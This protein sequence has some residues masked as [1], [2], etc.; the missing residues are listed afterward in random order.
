[1]GKF[2]LAGGNYGRNR[3]LSMGGIAHH[4][5]SQELATAKACMRVL[6]LGYIGLAMT[7][8]ASALCEDIFG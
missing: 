3:L 5:L 2:L 7:I 8:R 6:G 1:M 4:S